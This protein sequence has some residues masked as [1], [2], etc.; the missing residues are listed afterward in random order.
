M[1]NPLGILS[2]K[3]QLLSMEFRMRVDSLSLNDLGLTCTCVRLVVRWRHGSNHSSRLVVM[4]L[5]VAAA[6]VRRLPTYT[7]CPRVLSRHAHASPPRRDAL[8]YLSVGSGPPWRLLVYSARRVCLSPG[9]LAK[10]A[11]NHNGSTL[12]S[13]FCT[14]EK[15]NMAKRGRWRGKDD[16]LRLLS[17]GLKN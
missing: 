15:R 9:G 6:A 11:D 4:W 1:K 10:S 2:L 8:T 12:L 7:H 14:A 17:F 5:R 16:R 3:E 13:V